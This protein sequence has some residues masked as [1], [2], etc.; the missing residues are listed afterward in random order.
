MKLLD[1]T[2]PM[3]SVELMESKKKK[4][5]IEKTGESDA[6]H[7]KT[8]SPIPSLFTH[9]ICLPFFFFVYKSVHSHPC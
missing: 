1:E 7:D 5:K 6:T 2:Q 3:I 9:S 8:V 4:N